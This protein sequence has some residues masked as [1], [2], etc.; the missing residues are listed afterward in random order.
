MNLTTLKLRT[1]NTVGLAGATAGTEAT[2]IEGWAD[3]AALKFLQKTKAV[4]RTAQLVLTAGTGD[5]T[6]DADILA[7]EDVW[8][9][10][11]NG[12]QDYLLQAVDSYDIREMRL[13]EVSVAGP[14]GYFA[15]EGGVIMIY[16]NP[17]SSSDKLHIGYVPRPTGTFVGGV[18]TESWT[19]A[20]RGMIP[21]EYHDI[22]ESYVKWKAAQY[23]NDS[24]SQNGQQFRAEWEAG[25]IETKTTEN[26]KAG[27]RT[28]Y[29]RVGRRSQM[30]PR[31]PGIDVRI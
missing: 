24:A 23:S 11:A 25:L 3:E 19:D 4:K 18:G 8:V 21:L 26:R 2:L 27:M 10:P 7:F 12:S 13:A 6:L 9:D 22:L 20:T 30:I 29:A 5:Y 15:Y 28:S 16:P 31:H 1:Q 14:P 17:V